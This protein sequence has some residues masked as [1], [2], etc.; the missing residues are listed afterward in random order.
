MMTPIVGHTVTVPK[1]CKRRTEKTTSRQAVMDSCCIILIQ[2]E[3]TPLQQ[4]VVGSQTSST[5]KDTP[6]VA[7][8]MS[9][10]QSTKEIAQH[11]SSQCDMP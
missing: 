7:S 6:A 3:G 4:P 8:V 2:L 5:L 10:E 9:T 11:K 1:R